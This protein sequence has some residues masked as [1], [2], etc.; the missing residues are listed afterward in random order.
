VPTLRRASGLSLLLLVFALLAVGQA[1]ATALPPTTNP[2]PGSSFQGADGN[3]ND[4]APRIDWQGLEVAGRVYHNPDPNARDSA[5]ESSKENEPGEW[6]LGV[7]EG[8]VTPAKS[9]ILDAWS[10]VDQAGGEVFLYLAFTRADDAGTTYVA[11]ELNRDARL[12]NNGRAT[13]PC[14]RTG[15]ILVGYEAQGQDVNVIV[16][17]WVTTATHA[18]TG[19]ATAGRL[20]NFTG[21]TPNADAQGAINATAIAARLEGFY[22]NTIPAH[23]F[24]EAALNLSRILGE[25]FDDP[26]FSFGSIWMHSRSSSSDSSN[27]QDYVAPK[28]VSFRSCSASGMK[29]HDLNGNGRRDSGEPGLPRYL[30]W[31]DYDT[32]GVRDPLEPFAITDDDGQ[33]VINDI[34]RTYML[35]EA[36]ATVRGRRRAAAARVTCSYPND[37]T[38]GGTGSA[39]GGVFPCAW[40]PIDPAT[41]TN[42]RG[43][44]FGNYVPAQ[45]TVRKVL[46]PSTDPG[47]FDLLVDGVVRLPAAGDGA[48]R[49][50]DVRPGTHTVAETP[51][52]AT[53]AADYES[54]VECKLGARRRVLR[55]GPVFASLVVRSGE[56][57][58]CTFRNLRPGAPGIA[59]NK[60]GPG[61]A[62]A[63]DTLEYTLYVSN[64]GDLPFPAAAVVVRDPRCDQAPE[65]VGKGGDA[66]PGTLDPGDTWTYRCSLK[67]A[68][69]GDDCQTGTV[70]NTATVT[71]TAAGTSVSDSSTISTVLRCPQEPGPGP[72]PGPEPTPPDPV[73][74]VIPPGPQPPEAGDAAR[75]AF[76]AVRGCVRG[77][78]TR[79]SLQGTRIATVRVSVNGA[80]RAALDGRTLERVFS[81]RIAVPPG[82]RYRITARVAF[83]RGAGTPQVT[84]TRVVR[85]CVLARTAPFT[86]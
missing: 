26:C 45:L 41:T 80:F 30:I 83:E 65:L 21:F 2:L 77:T 20:E 63:G 58:V 82:T 9:N 47:R 19:C 62:T 15:D 32:D 56:S 42:A 36:I 67:T 11:F 71:G 23:R 4:A 69:P 33:Y 70:P 60:T 49:T 18:G 52:G 72:G 14:R 25:G 34:R 76:R 64:P 35:R 86:G 50:V 51:S 81:R 48:S 55:S 22:D 3:Q 74:P 17:R 59:I 31:A 68:A 10:A 73:S 38:P 13:I 16:Q 85:A 6:E 28:P 40:G 39:P 84:L 53:D 24:G 5:F 54:T 61:T 46:E 57:A 75:A 44:D 78:V 12:W 7:E 79:V 29:F 1:D 8:G 37:T 66:S 27:M 43:H